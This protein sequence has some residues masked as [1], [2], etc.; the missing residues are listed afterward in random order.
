[1]AALVFR[2]LI[3][4]WEVWKKAYYFS[5][6]ERG[7]YDFFL[8]GKFWRERVDLNENKTPA[9]AFTRAT[10]FCNVQGTFER[11]SSIYGLI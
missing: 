10:D 1:M 3:G 9:Q 7:Q 11:K 2:S 8:I 4:C 6:A 5:A